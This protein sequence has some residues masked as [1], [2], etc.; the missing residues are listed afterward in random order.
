MEEKNVSLFPEAICQVDSEKLETDR[1]LMVAA[2]ATAL[3]KKAETNSKSTQ[4]DMLIKK[5]R[6]CDVASNTEKIEMKTAKVGIRVQTHSIEVQTKAKNRGIES[7]SHG[8]VY[9]YQPSGCRMGLR[10]PIKFE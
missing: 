8:F 3:L 10:S 1:K 5:T 6:G 9:V 2:A 7:A 4:F